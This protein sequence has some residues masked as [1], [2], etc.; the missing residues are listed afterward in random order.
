MNAVT[1]FG[2][3]LLG[4]LFL[5]AAQAQE[6]GDDAADVLLTIGEQWLAQQ[7]GD[8]NWPE[9]MLAD[10]F[11]GWPSDSPAPRTKSST[12]NWNRFTEQMGHMVQ[13][14]IYPLSVVVRGDV[15]IAHYLYTSA[16]KDAAGDIKVSNGRYTDVLVR[17]DD[18]WKFLAWHGGS[19]D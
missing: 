8:S 13:H 9:T 2:L 6:T 11:M 14:E 19:D 16:L 18:G 5:G 1:R 17:T 3:L 4:T 7:Q 12:A 10:E 15:A